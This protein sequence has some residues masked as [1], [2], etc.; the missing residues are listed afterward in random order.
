MTTYSSVT[1]LHVALASLLALAAGACAGKQPALAP[2]PQYLT[3]EGA[4]Q[5]DGV[6]VACRDA[7]GSPRPVAAKD[8]TI[9]CPLR[10]HNG[11]LLGGVQMTC[12]E[13]TK[14]VLEKTGNTGKFWCKPTAP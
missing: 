9:A 11:R 1:T 2:P 12:K 14:P 10:P 3:V 13:G 8:G 5:L 4:N 7:D 6:R